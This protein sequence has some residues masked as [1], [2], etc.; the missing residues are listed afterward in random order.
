M[1]GAFYHVRVPVPSHLLHYFIALQVPVP[2]CSPCLV[3]GQH[4]KDQA[5]G[6]RPAGGHLAHGQAH[7][8]AVCATRGMPAPKHCSCWTVCWCA[9]NIRAAYACPTLPDEKNKLCN[10]LNFFKVDITDV[11]IPGI[12]CTVDTRSSTHSI[13]GRIDCALALKRVKRSVSRGVSTPAIHAHG[14]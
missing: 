2:C 6:R 7:E 5:L 8:G 13:M 12:V 14:L 4:D 9:S 1:H 11:S 10:K 3:A